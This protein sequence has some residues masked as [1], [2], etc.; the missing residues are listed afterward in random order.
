MPV[1]IIFV[2]RTNNKR[3]Y[4]IHVPSHAFQHAMYH[5]YYTTPLNFLT[6]YNEPL[7]YLLCP[8]GICVRVEEVRIVD[9]SWPHQTNKVVTIVILCNKKQEREQT[10][11]IEELSTKQYVP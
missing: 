11:L 7:A 9:T 3:R 2:A 10:S 6:L 8:V 1:Y 5:T 4:H